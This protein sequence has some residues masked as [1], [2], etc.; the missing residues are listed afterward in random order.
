MKAIEMLHI[1]KTQNNRL[2]IIWIV[3]FIAFIGL[4]GYTIYLLNDI[5]TEETTTETTNEQIIEDTDTIENSYIIN[6]GIYG[7]NKA[8]DNSQDNN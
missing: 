5:G 2:F 1:L 7:E 8:K 4:L 3:T 6:G